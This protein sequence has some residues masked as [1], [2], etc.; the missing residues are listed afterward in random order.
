MQLKEI[1][2]FREPPA[3]TFQDER[4]PSG[5]TEHPTMQRADANFSLS[6]PPP[7]LH[8]G[9]SFFARSVHPRQRDE[10]VIDRSATP[11]CLNPIMIVHV[12][13]LHCL[14]DLALSEQFYAEY[15]H[16]LRYTIPNQFLPRNRSVYRIVYSVVFKGHHERMKLY[17]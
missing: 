2:V 10:I 6:L 7:P 16:V 8:R 4:I 5:L 12:S 15:L 1:Y 11:F 13:L 17:S 14:L 9:F 3:S